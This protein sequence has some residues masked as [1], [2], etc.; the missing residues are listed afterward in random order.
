MPIK[1]VVKQGECLSSIAK[2][3]GFAD[4]RTIY[5]HP[6]N[7]E[8][9]RKRPDPN[10]I[11]PGDV[12][13]IPDKQ[14]K[15]EQRSTQQTHK[16]VTYK[17]D[18]EFKMQLTI[19][20]K[21]I[22]NAQYKLEIARTGPIFS[23]SPVP[24]DATRTRHTPPNAQQSDSIYKLVASGKTDANGWVR[25]NIPPDVQM[26][27]LWVEYRKPLKYKDDKGSEKQTF[28]CIK[29][30]YLI[31]FGYLNPIDNINDRVNGKEIITSVQQRLNNLGYYSGSADGNC[32]AKT[33]AAIKR[34]QTDHQLKVDGKVAPGGETATKLKTLHKS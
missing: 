29:I 22:S 3:Y 17:T 1:H 24:A 21:P 4:Y 31:F 28:I 26:G 9:K 16:F 8:L 2:Q 27:R 25:C 15:Q 11:Q 6:L 12:V 30:K 19:N 10:I 23:P 32:D 18:I 14:Q 13:W 7:A 34:F 33:I 5:D 20:F